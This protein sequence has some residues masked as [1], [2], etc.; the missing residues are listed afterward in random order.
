MPSYLNHFQCN[1]IF[2]SGR[3]RCAGLCARTYT[4]NGQGSG[5]PGKG[6]TSPACGPCLP[7]PIGDTSAGTVPCLERLP[8]K[9]RT[10]LKDPYDRLKKCCPSRVARPA[11]R[12]CPPSSEEEIPARSAAR[13]TIS[14]TALS[15]SWRSMRRKSGP[16]ASSST[17]TI[18]WFLQR[19]Y[20]FP[21]YCSRSYESLAAVYLHPAGRPVP[22]ISY[23]RFCGRPDVERLPSRLE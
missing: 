17:S 7:P 14:A 9:W 16:D 18:L 6:K 3:G 5:G 22:A 2:L 19:R 21:I 8:K 4:V 1:V 13:L 15:E 20:A 23:S 12:L 11:R 10:T